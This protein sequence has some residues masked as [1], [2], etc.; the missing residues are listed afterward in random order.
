MWFSNSYG[1]S[2]Q[3]FDIKNGKPYDF[4]ETP[5]QLMDRTFHKY[6]DVEVDGIGDR[7]INMYEQNPKNCD[8]SY[9]A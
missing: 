2:F 9:V 4:I 3:P 7:I 6:M 8:I 5:L 1:K